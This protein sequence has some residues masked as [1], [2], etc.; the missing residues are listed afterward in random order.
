M[1]YRLVSKDKEGNTRVDWF[2]LLILIGYIGGNIFILPVVIYTNLNEGLKSRAKPGTS[3]PAF[4]GLSEEE[5]NQRTDI[6]LKKIGDKISNY[7]DEEG[8]DMIT[9]KHGSQAKFLKRSLDYINTRL[10]PTDPELNKWVDE[11][12]TLYKDRT[13][14][15]FGGS[16]LIIGCSIGL[17]V[18]LG[19]F[20]LWSFMI[21]HGIGLLLYILASRIPYYAAERRAKFFSGGFWGGMIGGIFAGLFAGAS[22]KHFVKYGDGPW[23]RD[24]SA[25]LTNSFAM[26]LIMFVIA[27]IIGLF[28]AFLGV[29][30]FL[31]NYSTS[32]IIPFSK[33]N[34]A[35]YEKT[36]GMKTLEL[37][38]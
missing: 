6:L 37:K 22:T 10:L 13:R 7:K 5:R 31:M 30:N 2:S 19:Y 11:Y 21:W 9:I 1:A 12:S 4:E 16:K 38:V 36:C 8:N 29:V 26:I 23:Q 3:P 15:L 34:D 20:G 27:F 25:E 17:G 28:T 14:R 24:G 32:L 35:W 33:A 18:F